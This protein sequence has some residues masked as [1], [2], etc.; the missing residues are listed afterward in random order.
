MDYMILLIF[1]III[2]LGGVLFI[3]INKSL[4]KDGKKNFLTQSEKE[5]VQRKWQEIQQLLQL[6]GESRSKQAVL[7]GDKLVYF[8]LKKLGYSGDNMADCMKAA[9]ERFSSY[10][11]YS[12]LWKAHKCRNRIVH[13]VD[14]EL[15]HQ[16][17]QKTITRFER[18]LKDLG[19]L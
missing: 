9:K 2:L 13:E 14:N 6:E 4:P 15:L 5:M 16:E 10:K 8:V 12:E 18:V 19:V 3:F 11:I 1:G 7:E 17:A